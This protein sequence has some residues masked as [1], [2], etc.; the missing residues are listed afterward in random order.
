MIVKDISAQESAH[1][2]RT[3]DRFI[4]VGVFSFT[5]LV[6]DELDEQFFYIIRL[7]QSSTF[8]E[9]TRIHCQEVNCINTASGIVTLCKWPNGMQVEQFLLDL[10]AG[11]LV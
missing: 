6:D 5:F 8:F 10:H 3:F 4:K 9:Q 1:S 2:F 7:F 11:R